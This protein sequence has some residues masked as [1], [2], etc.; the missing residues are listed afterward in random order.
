MF[1]GDDLVI[2]GLYNVCGRN[3][4]FK[5]ALNWVGSCYLALVFLKIYHTRSLESSHQ[6]GCSRFPGLHKGLEGEVCRLDRKEM[7]HRCWVIY[8]EQ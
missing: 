4:Y 6:Q 8:L 7:L 2:P 5:L 1:A 3:A